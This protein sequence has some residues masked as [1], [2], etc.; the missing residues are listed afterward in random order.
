MDMKLF[1]AANDTNTNV[2]T[3]AFAVTREDAEAYL[4]NPGFGGANLYEIDVDI[5]DAEVLDLTEDIPDWLAE[6]IPGAYDCIGAIIGMTIGLSD[7]I[8]ER[9]YRWVRL[10]DSY[11]EDCVTMMLIGTDMDIEDLME[12]AE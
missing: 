10:I 5:S 6:L 8:A 11:P 7:A 9:G 4:D 12:A 2:D 1:R 3:T